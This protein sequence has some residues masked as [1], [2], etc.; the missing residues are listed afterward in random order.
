VKMNPTTMLDWKHLQIMQRC[1]EQ[2]VSTDGY[3]VLIDSSVL[4]GEQ[5][6]GVCFSTDK[7]FVCVP[8]HDE[9]LEAMSGQYCYRPQCFEVVAQFETWVSNG[10]MS[11]RVLVSLLKN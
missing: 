10:T 9:E 7:R 1:A 11:F 3:S 6:E 4:N 8:V 5:I 2:G